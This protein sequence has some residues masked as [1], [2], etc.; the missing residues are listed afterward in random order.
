MNILGILKS[1]KNIS[2]N[3]IGEVLGISRAAVHKQI[4]ALKQLGYTINSS[5][6]G[7]ILVDN[8]VLFNEYEIECRLGKTLKVC[9]TLRYYRKL[10]STQMVIKKL[11]TNGFDEGL[12]IVA[13]EQT[14]GYGRMEKPWSSNKGGLWFSMLLKPSMHPNE[15]AEIALL[16][17]IA[18][19]R[20]LNGKYSLKSLIKWPNDVL[21]NNKKIAG[22][23]VEMSAE[24]DKV[25][26]VVAGVGV[27]INNRLPEALKDSSISLKDVMKKEINRAEFMAEFLSIF[28]NLYV[29]FQRNGFE[30]F[31]EEYNAKIAYKGESITIDDGYNVKAGINLGIN[32]LGS[33]VLNT[34]IKLETVSSGTLRRLL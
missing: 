1:K 18:L 32:N 19:N 3:A 9:K 34:G 14:S 13:D 26:W 12:V 15:I 6:K 7:Y 30:Q 21:V 11:A 17:G 27:N 5:P 23:L 8:K 33:L 28:E 2:E 24:L 22:M 4:N 25:N 16:L 31:V 29:D 20:T 10:P